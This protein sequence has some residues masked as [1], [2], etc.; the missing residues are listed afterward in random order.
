MIYIDKQDTKFIMNFEYVAFFIF[1]VVLIYMFVQKRYSIKRSRV[2]IGIIVL[3]MI[4]TACDISASSLL[5]KIIDNPNPSHKM[6]LLANALSTTYFILLFWSIFLF[7]IYVVVITCGFDYIHKRKFFIAYFYLPVILVSILFVFNYFMCTVIH[8]SYE[9]GSI[10]VRTNIPFF[11]VFVAFG[12]LYLIQSILMMF[13]FKSVFERKQLQAITLVFPIM[14]FGMLTEIIFPKYLILSFMIA[15]FIILIQTVLESSEDL[16]DIKTRLLN[17]EE[18]NNRIRKAF[19]SNDENLIVVLIR[20]SNYKDLVSMH[21]SSA[22]NDYLAEQTKYIKNFRNNRRIKDEVYSL[23]N[24]YYASVF[25]RKFYNGFKAEDFYEDELEHGNNINYIP[26]FEFCYFEPYNDFDDPNEA[27]NFVNNYR[28]TI[29]FNEIFVRYSD[30]K[31]DKNFMIQNHLEQIID[32]A[33]RENEFKV[34]LQPIYSTSE[35]KFKSAE[36]L[37]RLISKKYGMISPGVFIPYAENTGRISEIDTFVMDKVFK[38]VSSPLFEEFGLDYIAINL[39]MAE[40]A[41]KG[42]VDKVKRLKEKY[43]INPQRINLEVTESYDPVD[44]EDIYKNLVELTKLGFKLSLDDY[45]TGYSNINRFTNIPISILK[46][47]K[48]LVDEF[49]DENIKKILD[50]SFDIVNSLEK[51]TVVEG[52]ETKEQLDTFLEYGASYIQGFYF[53]KPLDIDSY[54]EFLKKNN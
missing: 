41:G 1:I 9:D 36:A 10:I 45:G 35:K 13:K 54:I 32:T 42:I 48:S 37:V 47:D 14:F 24:G 6:V 33:I 18:F 22:I 50:F 15:M 2:F 12:S 26:R 53:S 21:S 31:N 19:Y 34:Y 23:N 11:I 3:N 20:M 40:C 30:V 44:Q 5:N 39:S 46:I 28:E 4:N 51:Q 52:V 29:Q 38:L 27:I 17:I 43:N 8:Y 25:K 7:A 16:I 49:N